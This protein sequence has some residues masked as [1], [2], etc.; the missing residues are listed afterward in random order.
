VRYCRAY[1]IVYSLIELYAVEF[2]FFV[3]S[4]I[5]Q[6]VGIS[7]IALT[8]D[9]HFSSHLSFWQESL[10]FFL[11]VMD[12]DISKLLVAGKCYSAYL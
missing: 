1:L 12:T 4:L 11:P 5:G 7:F 2:I 9:D 8:I 10:Y 3:K 6:E